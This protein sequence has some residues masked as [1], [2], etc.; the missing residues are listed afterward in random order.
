MNE[1]RRK[2]QVLLEMLA[3]HQNKTGIYKSRLEVEASNLNQIRN[4][5]YIKSAQSYGEDMNRVLSGYAAC[6][7]IA[8]LQSIESSINSRIEELEEEYSRMQRKVLQLDQKINSL[9][10]ELSRLEEK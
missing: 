9:Y 6:T 4:F 7:A 3:E 8:N 2:I 5:Q 10:R 1:L